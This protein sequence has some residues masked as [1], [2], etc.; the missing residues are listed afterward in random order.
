MTARAER[1]ECLFHPAD[2]VVDEVGE[3][4]PLPETERCNRTFDGRQTT[5]AGELAYVF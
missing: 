1:R 2:A 4:V 5:A 3:P